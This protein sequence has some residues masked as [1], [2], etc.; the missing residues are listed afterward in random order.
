MH[1]CYL[2]LPKKKKTHSYV[3]GAY[4]SGDHGCQID[5]H[6]KGSHMDRSSRRKMIANQ[7]FLLS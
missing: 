3:F 4:T 5:R 1:Y 2:L 6:S 7:L